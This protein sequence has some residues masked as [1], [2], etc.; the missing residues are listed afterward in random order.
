MSKAI[1]TAAELTGMG[2]ATVRLWSC[3]GTPHIWTSF[4]RHN[5]SLGLMLALAILLTRRSSCLHFYLPWLLCL[6]Y[7][8]CS[9]FLYTTPSPESLGKVAGSKFDKEKTI[10][11]VLVKKRRV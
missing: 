6:T 7:P 9:F 4:L 3:L 5:M 2:T 8:V 1:S 11:I 10:N